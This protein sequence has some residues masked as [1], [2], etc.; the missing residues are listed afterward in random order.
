MA[1]VMRLNSHT[2]FGLR[3]LMFLVSRPKEEWMT[4]AEIATALRIPRNHLLKVVHRMSELGWVES[5]RGPSGGVR[6]VAAAEHV[7]V[8]EVVRGL[9]QNLTLVECFT[10]ETNRCPLD[11]VCRLAPVLH[12]A[13]DAFLAE[14]DE[15]VIGQLVPHQRVELEQL[16]TSMNH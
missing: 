7:T 13:R 3:T 5:K 11:Q 16:I 6:F 14:L 12:R 15:V 1:I 4:T 2:D 9:E 8:G 10:S